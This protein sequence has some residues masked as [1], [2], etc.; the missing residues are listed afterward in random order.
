MHNLESALAF[1]NYQSTLTQQKKVIKQ[2]FKDNCVLAYNGGLFFITPEFIAGMAFGNADWV[3]DMNGNPIKI[4]V[5]KD[6]VDLATKTY[7]VAVCKYGEAYSQLKTQ[8]SVK[9]L[10]GI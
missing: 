7:N 2:Q 5:R 9:S 10:V 4:D 6:F 8:R 3:I 1:A